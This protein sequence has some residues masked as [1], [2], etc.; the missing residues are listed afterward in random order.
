[1]F[2]D[3]LLYVIRNLWVIQDLDYFRVPHS[4]SMLKSPQQIWRFISIPWQLLRVQANSHEDQFPAFTGSSSLQR[5]S[6][7]SNC[8]K[9][10]LC[11]ELKSIRDHYKALSKCWVGRCRFLSV[12]RSKRSHQFGKGKRSYGSLQL[13]TLPISIERRL[14]FC[15]RGKWRRLFPKKKTAGTNISACYVQGVLQTVCM[16]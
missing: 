9:G 6:E 7:H 5:Q 10:L 11:I 14:E 4:H 12:Q 13:Q 8:W 1:M 2:I 16:V 3:T 15:Q